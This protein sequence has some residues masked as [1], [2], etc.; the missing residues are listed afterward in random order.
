MECLLCI[1]SKGLSARLSERTL[2]RNEFLVTKLL[3]VPTKYEI[4]LTTFKRIKWFLYLIM[5]VSVGF[6]SRNVNGYFYIPVIFTVYKAL[7]HSVSHLILLRILWDVGILT[8]FYWWGKWGLEGELA[9]AYTGNKVNTELGTQSQIFS[10]LLCCYFHTTT[11]APFIQLIP[12]F[13]RP[14]SWTH[15]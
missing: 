5:Y 14:S 1:L 15:F 13:H 8:L 6:V 3:S 11:L 10:P 4:I 12:L 9:Q 2:L 7:V